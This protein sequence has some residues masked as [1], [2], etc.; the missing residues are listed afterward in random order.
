MISCTEKPGSHLVLVEFLVMR[1][2]FLCNSRHR[3]REKYVRGAR[4]TA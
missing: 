1:R 3:E 4:D 2:A